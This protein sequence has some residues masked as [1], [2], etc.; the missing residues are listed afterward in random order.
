MIVWKVK[1]NVYQSTKHRLRVYTFF[2][3]FRGIYN[4]HWFCIL[5]M[6][7]F[8]T[9]RSA[10]CMVEWFTKLPWRT[11]CNRKSTCSMWFWNWSVDTHKEKWVNPTILLCITVVFAYFWATYFCMHMKITADPERGHTVI[12]YGYKSCLF[13]C[14]SSIRIEPFDL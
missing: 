2:M 9:M 1:L 7:S 10:A 4:I 6:R 14:N 13:R 11:W 3:L 5:K 8:T 12:L